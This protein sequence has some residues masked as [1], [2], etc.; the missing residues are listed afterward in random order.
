MSA[1]PHS[2]ASGTTPTLGEVIAV[3]ETLY[4]LPWAEAWDRV[5]LVVGDVAEPVF[6]ILL[7]VDPTIGVAADAEEHDLL[8]T[9]HPLLLRGASFLPTSTGKGAV[10]TSLIRSRTALWCGHTNADRARTGTATTLA[11]V[12]DLADRTPL[13]PPARAEEGLLGLGLLGTLPETGTVAGL[14][15]QLSDALPATVQGA[16]FTGKGE[17]S[18]RRVA[19]CPGAG[20]SL[21]DRVART[22]ADVFITSDLRH[23]PALEHLESQGDPARVPALIDIPHWASESMWLPLLA[24]LLRTEAAMRGW[25]LEVRVSERRTDPWTGAARS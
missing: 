25:R 8:V 4:P 1:A 20:D 21:L 19:L 2:S 12:L 7:A 9:H 24:Q 10:V 22:D 15:Q 5:G 13:E 6:R 11:D 16:V 3:L 23:H 17:R 18:V 14:A